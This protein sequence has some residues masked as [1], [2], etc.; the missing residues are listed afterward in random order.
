MAKSLFQK[1]TD[2]ARQ[3]VT[4]LTKAS[5]DWFSNMIT[6]GELSGSVSRTKLL[7]DPITK[8]KSRPTIGKMYMFVYDPKHKKTLPYYDRFPLI[9]LAGRPASA[10]IS[11]K[12]E[13]FYG[14]NLHYLRPYDRA[15]FLSRLVDTYATTS[16]LTEK[17]RLN[18]SYGL[19]K[20]ASKMR[21]YAP[22]FKH[23]LPGHV[24]SNIVEVPGNHWETALWLPTQN[25]AKAT[26]TKVW[27]QSK[28]SYK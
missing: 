24:K 9:I 1:Y 5:R 4:P 8:V 16:T 13:G 11:K 23:Y 14:L 7:R 6:S 10:K 28:A 25:F 22:T 3:D 21:A 2:M 27:S 20:A 19:L 12:A 18:L 17:T 15:V 26:T